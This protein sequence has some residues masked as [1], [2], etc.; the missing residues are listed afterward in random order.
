MP[1]DPRLL[2]MLSYHRDAERHGATLRLRL[3]AA[4]ADAAKDARRLA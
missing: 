1:A 2:G 4:R 3:L